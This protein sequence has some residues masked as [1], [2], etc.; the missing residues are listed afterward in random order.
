MLCTPSPQPS[1][2]GRGSKI[3]FPFSPWE[4]GLGDE[5]VQ[6]VSVPINSVHYLSTILSRIRHHAHHAGRGFNSSAV[7]FKRRT[8]SNSLQP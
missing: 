1:P 6:S 3:W 8:H 2:K 4:K 7:N 5:G